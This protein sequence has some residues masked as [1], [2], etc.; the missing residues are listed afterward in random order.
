M[1]TDVNRLA[2]ITWLA[3]HADGIGRTALMKYCYFLQVVGGVPLGYHFSL[4]SY[5]PFDSEVLS[6]L[7]TAEAIGSV[8]APVE[9]YPGGYGYK[10]RSGTRSDR[11]QQLG[12]TFLE[13]YK[14]EFERVVS[15]FHGWDASALEIASTLVYSDRETARKGDKVTISEV[16]RRVRELKPRFGIEQIQAY[17]QRLHEWGFLKAVG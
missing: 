14:R 7:D 11:I 6:D 13:Q 2:A 4:Y 10:I 1:S 15:Q 3:E 5:G 8:E 9:Y 12:Q 16:S 17:A